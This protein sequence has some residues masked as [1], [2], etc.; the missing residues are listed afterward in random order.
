[1]LPSITQSQVESNK[2]SEA[3]GSEIAISRKV[4]SFGND[5]P[6]QKEQSIGDDKSVGLQDRLFRSIRIGQK[7]K[8]SSKV[9]VLR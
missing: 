4:V 1:M 8:G 2:V 6:A 9:T 3:R 5:P 7:I